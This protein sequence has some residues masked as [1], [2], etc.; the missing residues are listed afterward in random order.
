MKLLGSTKNKIYKDKNSENVPHLEFTEVVLIHCNIVNKDY[1]QNSRVLY[2]FVP[3]KSF[4]QLLDIS[5]KKFYIF[6][7]N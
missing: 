2:T 7:K 1:Q 5:S 3:N 6:K 4:G